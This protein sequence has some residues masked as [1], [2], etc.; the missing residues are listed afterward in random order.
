[1]NKQQQEE[2]E[3]EE[4]NSW[5]EEIYDQL[6]A[7]KNKTATKI[8]IEGSSVR[9]QQTKLLVCHYVEGIKTEIQDWSVMPPRIVDGPKMHKPRFHTEMVTLPNGNVAA[10]GGVDYLFFSTFP[11]G[12]IFKSARSKFFSIG[13]MCEARERP[14]GVLLRTNVVFLCGGARNT[15]LMHLQ[16]CEFYDPSTLKFTPSKA[17]LNT[18]RAGHTATLLPDGTVLVAGGITEDYTH[19]CSTEIYN[20]LT[21][22][23]SVGP[24]MLFR[25]SGHAA[26]ALE[27][28][29]V[30]VC[31]NSSRKTELYDHA[32]RS[33]QR[34]PD[35]PTKRTHIAAFLLPDGRVVIMGSKG[36]HYAENKLTEIFDPV[37]NRITAGP[38]IT[39]TYKLNAALF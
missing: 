11:K 27:D 15:S 10:F 34:G 33:F 32:T 14:A 28:G 38:E 16:S 29:R 4:Q 8:V 1:M 30:F 26:V 3:E 7:L 39:N 18:G 19:L 6:V 13:D 31:G 23:F 37:T 5:L 36:Q 25:H 22:S 9:L 12:E 2:E 35:V 20:P 24:Q 17:T 21:D